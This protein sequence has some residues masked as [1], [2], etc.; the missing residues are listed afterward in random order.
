MRDRN[1][2]F[3]QLPDAAVDHDDNDLP[4]LAPFGQPYLEVALPHLDWGSQADDYASDYH[5]NR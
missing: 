4:K 3:G 1:A 2:V 5:P